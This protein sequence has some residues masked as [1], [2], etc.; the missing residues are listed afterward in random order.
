MSI[1]S[2][3]SRIVASATSLICP[4]TSLPLLIFPLLM[5]ILLFSTGLFS[6]GVVKAED[7]EKVGTIE[8]S[9][10]GEAI[11]LGEIDVGDNY[12]V[13]DKNGRFHVIHA[14]KLLLDCSHCHGAESYKPDYLNVSKYKA[15]TPKHRGRI[16][17]TVCLG[18]HQS[19]GMGTPWYTGSTL[20]EDDA[21]E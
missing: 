14:D 4:V 17:K 5:A 9:R 12:S 2:L 1:N 8:Y 10:A 6:V 20:E 16:E 7:N 21:D 18:C 11:R 3:S 15:L 19:G 13:S